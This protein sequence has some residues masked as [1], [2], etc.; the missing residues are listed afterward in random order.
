MF[1]EFVDEFGVVFVNVRRRLF[2]V[3]RP[4]RNDD[5]LNPRPANSCFAKGR[6][7]PTVIPPTPGV[8]DIVATYGG[9][10]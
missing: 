9:G 7:E 5:G 3:I 6:Y 4:E 1:G 2:R 10:Q 8:D